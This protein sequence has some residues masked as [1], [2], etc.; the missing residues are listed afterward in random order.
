MMLLASLV[1]LYLASTA[2]VAIICDK[3][4]VKLNTLTL[5]LVM[6][7]ILNSLLS[8]YFLSEYYKE[9]LKRMF[10]GIKRD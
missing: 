6:C 1:F 5:F 9:S 4:C 3:R 10:N 7:P 8:L 2:Y